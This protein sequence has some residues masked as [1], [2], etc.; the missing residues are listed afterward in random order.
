LT[1]TSRTALRG[2]FTRLAAGTILLAGC[3]VA[4]DAAERSAGGLPARYVL[5]GERVFPEGIAA[6]KSTGDFFVSST[7]DGTIYRGN[8][9]RARVDVFLPGG[10]DGRTAATGVRVRDGRLWV[11]GRFTGR[12]FVYDIES[13]RLVRAFEAPDVGSTFSPRPER[14]LVNDIAFAREAAY[15]TDSFQP[16]VYRVATE[17]GRLGAIEPW[18][19]LRETPAR[20]RR[21][22]NLNGITVSDDERYLV[23]VNYETGRLYR[24]DTRTRRVREID[25]G[26]GDVRTGD[27]LLLDGTTLLV[28]REE[29]G[30]ITPV[31]LSSDLLRGKIG[32]GFGASR[33]RFPTS[34]FEL[35]GRGIVV[36]SQ[37]DR[38]EDP[39]LPF[40]VSAVPIPR[41]TLPRR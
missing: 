1:K 5:P 29:P 16:V 11:A 23:T 34:M 35:G 19:D 25:L 15:I 22:Y 12:V 30:E 33:L 31:K 10:R 27:G 39:E 14:S 8:V 38:A 26:G 17:S 41:G 13:K 20:Y 28:V 9:R 6:Q 7:T 37:L 40:T 24:I 18:L 3:G 36:N 32:R 21:G 2:A 4:R